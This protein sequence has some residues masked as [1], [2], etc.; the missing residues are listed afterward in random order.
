M[1]AV[2][3]EDMS[4]ALR[5]K[6]RRSRLHKSPAMADLVAGVRRADVWWA[7][8][9]SDTRRLYKRTVL[10]PWWITIQTGAFA[11]GI[12]VVYGSLFGIS[13][14]EYLPFVVLGLI[15]W[16]F[17]G[18]SITSAVRLFLEPGNTVKSPQLALSVVIFRGV[19][20]Q[21]IQLLHN[22][23]LFP[24]L[25]IF[26]RPEFS[27]R[28]MEVL[29]AIP[30]LLFF[31]VGLCLILGPLGARFRDLAPLTSS[32]VQLLF[33]LTPV[34]WARSDL[35][36]GALLVNLNPLAY[37]LDMLRSPLMGAEVSARNWLVSSGTAL[38]ALCLGYL[39]FRVTWLKIR[40]WA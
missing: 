20:K 25:L 17:I 13:T 39:V 22:L 16:S 36:G 12:G 40:Y 6:H 1:M 24:V 38:A 15:G 18:G 3:E 19:A 26:V 9:V 23:A 21:F 31:S 2:I 28:Q 33:F 5:A 14:E 30:V 7:L 34:F 37:M 11:V 10:G 4:V 27:W 32:L 8:A 35:G 29:A